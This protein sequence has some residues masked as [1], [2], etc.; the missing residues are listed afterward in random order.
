MQKKR[1]F[2]DEKMNVRGLQVPHFSLY[3]LYHKTTKGT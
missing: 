3:T 2:A 1:T